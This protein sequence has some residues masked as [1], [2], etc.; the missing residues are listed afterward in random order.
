MDIH[1]YTGPAVLVMAFMSVLFV[2]AQLLK[3]NSIVDIFWGMGFVTIVAYYVLVSI[4]TGAS[5]AL[6]SVKSIVNVCV[7][8]WGIRL[9]A[10]ILLKNFGQPED[11]RYL[12][13]RKLWTRH[14]IP[15]WLGAFL[16]VFMLQGFFMLIVALPV[17]HV[18][19]SSMNVNA[20]TFLGFA[21]WLAGFYFETVGDYQKTV[22]K[23][24]PENKG[25]ILTTGLWKYTRHPN[26]F[27]ESVMWWGIWVMSLSL[28]HPVISFIG[29]LSPITMTWLLTSVSGVPM[30]ESKY[31]KNEAYQQY[32]K[33]TPA[34]FPKFR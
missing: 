24:N 5:A 7:L 17:I 14:N 26:Y 33:N 34:F 16:Q 15:H 3:N 11:W 6:F 30:L 12:N 1:V 4:F 8:I 21:L 23:R 18:N 32:V 10:H 22:F 28:A 20:V 13:F 31:S 29:I 27:G 9:S 25:K 19:S 2:I